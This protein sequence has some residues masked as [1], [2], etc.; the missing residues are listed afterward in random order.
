LEPAFNLGSMNPSNTEHADREPPGEPGSAGDSRRLA[1]ELARRTRELQRSETRFRDVIEGNA[2]AIVVVGRDGVIRFANRMATVLFG[3]T[4]QDLVGRSFGFPVV[5]DETTEVDLLNGGKPKAAEMRVVASEWDGE[6]AFIASLRDVTERKIAEQSERRLIVE[7]AARSAAEESVRRL[8]FLLDSSSAL[9]ASLDIASIFSALAKVCVSAVADWTIIY[10][11]DDAGRLRR[12]EAAHRDPDVAGAMRELRDMTTEPSSAH[13]ILEVIRS[14]K[15]LLVADVGNRQLASV[16]QNRR[17]LEL[18]HELGIASFLAV[19]L[20][21]RGRTIGAIALIASDSSRRFTEAHVALAEDLAIRAGLAIENARLFEEANAAN[22]SKA[23]FLAVVSHD[24]RT[25]LNA[26][27]G[28]AD[29]LD[30]GIP[31]PLSDGSRSHVSRIQTS[32]KHL[33]YLLNELLSF[34]RL[35]AGGETLRP[36]DTDVCALTHEVAAVV[37]PMAEQKGLALRI[38][39][40]DHPIVAHTDADKL[41]Q[42]LLNLAMN[43]VKYTREGTVGIDIG[44]EPQRIVI[45]V[46]DTGI[47]IRDDHLAQIFEPFWQADPAQRARDGGTGLGLSVVKRMADMLAADV[48][49]SSTIGEGSAFT[50]TLP[51]SA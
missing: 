35:E 46:R 51:R 44:V 10:T 13:P 9:V 7:Q 36:S 32:A 43:A 3:K 6:P 31:D 24:L 28:Y 39:V 17:E 8:R 20:V 42:V 16:T 40:P 38:S 37:E 14:R 11:I 2:D 30:T 49:V 41:R 34:A 27:I 50:V 21:G 18:V 29:L 12:A 4:R 26:I 1:S 15:P 33:I 19:P 5:A 48:R 47:G 22:R 23:N 25:P 45:C